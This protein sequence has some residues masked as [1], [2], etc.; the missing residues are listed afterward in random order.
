MTAMTGPFIKH[1]ATL[2]ANG[3]SIVPIP[4][5]SKGPV[6]PKWR[7]LNIETAQQLQQ[8][9]DGTHEVKHRGR[10]VRVPNVRKGD[11]VG[12]LATN[13]PAIDIDC[14]DEAIGDAIQR[15]VFDNI[16]DAPIRVGM[17]PKRLL[18]FR[19]DT[20]FSKVTSAAFIDPENPTKADGKQLV[21][22]VEVLAEGQQFVAYHTHP[23]TKAPYVWTEDFEEPLCLKTSE[24]P[25][26][27]VEQAKGICRE[28]ERLC[29]LRGWE[30][31]TEAEGS[32]ELTGGDDLALQ[33]PPGET[34]SEIERVKSAL[35]HISPD[36]TRREYL[37]VLAA[38][39][40]TGWLCAEEMAREWA[41]GSKEGKFDESHFNRDWGSFKQERG[42]K[43][44]TLGTIFHAAKQA[45]WD[46]SRAP[47]EEELR[48]TFDALMIEIDGLGDK[49][50]RDARKDLIKR[51]SAIEFDAIDMAE[52]VRALAKKL[53]MPATDVRKAIRNASKIT[54]EHGEPTHANYARRLLKNLEESTGT[55]P[56]GVEGKLWL[57]DKNEK[58]WIGKDAAELEVD[59]AKAFDGLDGCVRRTDYLA[60]ANHACSIAAGGNDA[61]FEDAAIGMACRGRFYRITDDKIVREELCAEHR[62]RVTVE[63][64][65]TVSE[66]PLWD[67]LMAAAFAGDRDREQELL[68]EEYAGACLLGFAHKYEKVLFMKG[69]GRA[70]KG[71]IMKVIESLVPRQAISAL[72][73]DVWS[74]EYYLADLAGKRLNVVGE[75]SDEV[76]IDSAAFKRVTGRDELTGRHPTHRPFKFRN[77][78]GHIFNANNFVFTKDHTDP[79]YARWIMMEFRNSM[80][81][82]EGDIDPNLAEKIVENELPG[83]CARF[84]QGAKR[85]VTRGHF[86]LTAP[87]FKLMQQWRHRSSTLMEF[88]NDRDVCVLGE[89][90]RHELSR[91]AFYAAYS[92]WCKNSNRKPL[93]KQKL[94]DEMEGSV[95]Q[96]MRVRFAVKSGGSLL[97]RGLVLRSM[98][99]DVEVSAAVMGA[100]D[101]WDDDL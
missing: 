96:S 47:D 7:H 46:A 22:R 48:Q 64:Q 82:R 53:K 59:V 67:K 18:V 12:I 60:I 89:F 9:I 32:G 37:E 87:H 62:Q 92:E 38:M 4:L 6:V 97:V 25:S 14:L 20:P 66:T 83:V 72:S 74:R 34:T 63:V 24:L 95:V 56:V 57:F 33:M 21:Q 65:P 81:G 78:A 49:A 98:L 80:I 15:F 84:L 36:G 88:L 70:G 40:W 71:T 76:P 69:V 73:P 5:G 91:A 27:D 26:L 75:L 8:F 30:K 55:D 43:T 61:F 86:A 41:E 31:A 54:R 90:P 52:L 44:I 35:A 10:D 100:G 17:W 2:L 50:D 42:G 101:D 3:W 94:Y 77:A 16:D 58:I 1:G 29:T 39:R 68:L 79:F 13:T 51:I 93:G 85:L 23:D 11:G 99:F 19:T 28:F 45:G